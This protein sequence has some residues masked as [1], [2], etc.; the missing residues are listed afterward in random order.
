MNLVRLR[1][2]QSD[3]DAICALAEASGSR[4]T[5]ASVAGAPPE[6]YR[7]VLRCRSVI[8]FDGGHVRFGEEH[9]LRLYLPAQYPA[10]APVATM[11][12]PLLNPHVWPNRTVCLGAWSMAE[13]L[14]SVVLRIAALLVLDPAALNWRSVADETIVPW[15]KQNHARLPLDGPLGQGRSLP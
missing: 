13:K 4:L 6:T 5:I 12:T 15:V 7:L 10:V 9:H 14:D 11:L 3:H 1:R 2:L 8:G